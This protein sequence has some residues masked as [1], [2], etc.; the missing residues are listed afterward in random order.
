MT[1]A[2]P[3]LHPPTPRG[4]FAARSRWPR[5]PRATGGPISRPACASKTTS[6]PS[7]RRRRTRPHATAWSTWQWWS[8]TIQPRPRGTCP[9][10]AMKCCAST[11]RRRP[12][13]SPR[14]RNWRAWTWASGIAAY[15]L[16]EWITVRD[17]TNQAAA[18]PSPA[19][20]D[21]VR[22]PRPSARWRRSGRLAWSSSLVTQGRA[23]TG[24]S[25]A[26]G[27]DW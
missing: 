15:C 7:R 13:R 8:V 4:S 22:L 23:T 24:L 18:V 14:S 5:P 25:A 27:P 16:K 1:P 9:R 11:F 3:P 20:R 26:R 19:G 17:E 10:A 21:A 12:S 6:E 2:R